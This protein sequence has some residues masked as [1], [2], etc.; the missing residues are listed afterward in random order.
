MS[1][2]IKVYLLSVRTRMKKKKQLLNYLK[3]EDF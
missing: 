2:E 1:D 3:K